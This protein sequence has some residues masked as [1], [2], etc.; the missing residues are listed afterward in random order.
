MNDEGELNPDD[1]FR[2]TFRHFR[3]EINRSAKFPY[4]DY[5]LREE[6]RLYPQVAPPR[7]KEGGT[8][9]SFNAQAVKNFLVARNW[10]VT[11]V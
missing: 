9:W 8:E 2:N 6:L 11:D 7:H 5:K 3:D 1:E 10:W 4:T